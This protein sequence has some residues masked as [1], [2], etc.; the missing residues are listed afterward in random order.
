MGCSGS[1]ASSVGEVKPIT[2]NKKQRLIWLAGC[3]SAGKT[4]MGDY[5]ATRGFHHIDGDMGNQMES[6]EMKTMWGNLH[7]SMEAFMAKT[8]VKEEEWKPYYEFLIKEYKK[9][10][11]TGKDIVLS[12]AM[13]DAFGEC[14]WL[15]KE[16]PGLEFFVLDVNMD[17]I[18]RRSLPR[19]KAFMIAA[20]TT[21]EEQWN[22][23]AIAAYGPFSEEAYEKATREQLGGMVCTPHPNPTAGFTFIKNDDLPSFEGI[24]NI[25]RELGL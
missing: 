19:N 23:E 5:L 24:K 6:E 10:I 12:F 15:K 8:E 4:F 18:V 21:V 3:S 25:N 13:C 7:K 16:I 2:A 14:E 22:E 9:A 17:E 20:G 1:K 11:P